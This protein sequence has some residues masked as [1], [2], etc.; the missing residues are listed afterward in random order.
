MNNFHAV[1][2]SISYFTFGDVGPLIEVALYSLKTVL[3][4]SAL[5]SGSA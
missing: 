2:F 4:V 3:R 5:S 1:T